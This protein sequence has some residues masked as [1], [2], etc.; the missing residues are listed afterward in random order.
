[1]PIWVWVIIALVL[2]GSIVIGSGKTTKNKNET[3]SNNVSVS[4]SAS[5]SVENKIKVFNFNTEWCGY[6]KQ[7]QGEWDSFANQANQ[8]GGVEAIDIKC[9]KPENEEMCKKYEIPGYPSIVIEKDGQRI[10]YE[11][12]RSASGLM[13]ELNKHL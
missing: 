9:D 4:D 13:D 10:D 1:M 2:C 7:F 11:G 3:F 8:I 6:S 5:S 12:P